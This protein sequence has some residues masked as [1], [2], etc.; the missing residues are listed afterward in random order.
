[1]IRSS[2]WSIVGGALFALAIS[3]P[4]IAPGQGIEWKR[5]VLNE[6]S[7]FEAAGVL[8][9]NNDGTLDIMC[10]DTWYAGPKWEPHH[11]CD[12][13][14]DGEYRIDFANV[15]MDVNGDGWADIVS[16]NW[17]RQSVVWREN[18]G[19]KGGNWIERE[20]DKPGNSETAI[21][22]DVDGDGKI[23]F[24]PDVAQKTIWYRLENGKISGH[25]V[26]ATIGGHG[27]GFGDVNGDG[28]KDILKPGGWFEAPEERLKGTWIWHADWNLGATGEEIITYDFNGDG[29]TDLFYAMGHDFGTFWLEQTKE[30]EPAKK[31]VTHQVDK[32]W[33]Q[34]HSLRLADLDRDGMPDVVTGKRKYAHRTDPGAE[35]PMVI[36]YYSFNRPSKTFMRQEI[37][38]GDGDG[39]GLGPVVT[40]IDGDGD[41]DLVAPGKSG[42]YLFQQENSNK[43]VEPRKAVQE[44]KVPEGFEITLFASEPEIRKPIS[45]AFDERGRMVIC[46]AAEYPLG[47]KPGEKPQDA[48]KILE[49]A[50]G[51]G[52]ADLIKTFADG[53][54]IPDAVAVGHGG[55]YVAEAPDLWFM[56]DTNG[57]DRADEKKSILTNFG[58]QD[59]HHNVHGLIW[60]PEGK[61]L[62]SQGCSTTSKIIADGKEWS[63]IEGNFFRCW[64]DGTGFEVPFRGFTNSWGYD[65]D[66]FG[67][68]VCN[69]NEGPHLIHLVE[70]GDYGFSLPNRHDGKPGTLPGMAT[71]H[72]QHY[73]YLIQSGLTIY[74]GDAFPEEYNGSILQGAPGM[75]KVIR[76]SVEPHGASFL[77]SM[78]T[79]LSST[80]DPWH[81]AI[82]MAVGPDGA[83][84]VLDWY[85]EILAHVEHPLD[86]PRRDKTHGRIYR[87]AWKGA[88]KEPIADLRK[89][90]V[91]ELVANVR[92]DNKWK[93]R[94]S[95][96][97]LAENK[98]EAA[99]AVLRLLVPQEKARTRCH[100]L[101]TLEEMRLAEK[102]ETRAGV[103]HAVQNSLSDPDSRV[104]TVAARIARHIGM[105]DP[106]TLKRIVQL[107]SDTDDFVK[108]EAAL[109]VASLAQ[110]LPLEEVTSMIARADWED[111][112]LAHAFTEAIQPY[113][114]Q[115]VMH[116]FAIGAEGLNGEGEKFLPALLHL[117]DARTEPLFLAFLQL[118]EIKPHLIDELVSGLH[119]FNSPA[120]SKG[121]VAFLAQHPDL[122]PNLI[123]P[124]LEDLRRRPGQDELAKD[125]SIK[126][127]LLKLAENR[128]DSLLRDIFLTASQIGDR[129]LAPRIVDEI[130]NSDAKISESAILSCGE[131]G[132]GEAN[133]QLRAM[134]DQS[135]PR[136]KW[137]T[138]RAL[139]KIGDSSM[140]TVFEEALSDPDSVL[141]CIR[142]LRRIAKQE[143]YKQSLETALRLINEGKVIVNRRTA[144][145]LRE[146]IA[147]DGNAEERAAYSA[148][149]NGFEGIMRDWRIMGPFPNPDTKGHAT[150]YPPESAL[151]PN[152]VCRAF[153]QDLTWQ[154]LHTDDAN[155]IVSLGHLKPNDHVV[156]YAWGTIDSSEERVGTLYAGSDDSIKAWVNGELVLDHLVDRGLEVDQDQAPVKLKKGPNT[157]LVKIGQNGG[158]W[159]FHARIAVL[160]EKIQRDPDNA[161]LR[162]M[163][164]SGDLKRGEKVFF[165][166]V[167]CARCHAVGDKGGRVGPDLS[168]V[169][170]LNPKS[171]IVRSILRPSEEIAEGYAG[172]TI[173]LNS[174]E[175]FEGYIHR[176]TP[177]EVFLVT[178]EGKT[179]TIPKDKI[180]ERRPHSTSGMPDDIAKNITAQ[181]L[182]DLVAFL[183]ERS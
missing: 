40:D 106:E 29:L 167:G 99:A 83:V 179:I 128:R 140:K 156:A 101:W 2:R 49:D 132:L 152:A 127:V 52:H 154:N 50:D 57:D 109:T 183:E 111:P 144:R 37:H 124:I 23:D 1:M 125:P 108:C 65:W 60:G 55:I 16:C 25:E 20:V 7:N 53:L 153:D 121:L 105:N 129:A 11:A 12:I 17:H 175:S 33:S 159:N 133:P 162:A 46:E 28:R 63:L 135:D 70:G 80:E 68:W 6:K 157:V 142:G 3:L 143:D 21:A 54:R 178:A 81:R 62:M 164:L 36:F 72:Q 139:S 8:D 168:N 92:S 134:L 119:G 141:D 56:R 174:N 82:A 45:L 94:I 66:D 39:L 130:H 89:S 76:D 176:E 146:W 5:T 18:P 43:P 58:T 107:T 38:R 10:G 67:N 42:L 171:Y 77:A 85:N 87:I 91:Q 95:Q 73:G 151:D 165:G 14:E 147:K 136:R 100:A 181:E 22:V 69:D 180:K 24:L 163:I 44:F 145:E 90:T 84:Y 35:D 51:D 13:I 116:G 170:R 59:S 15:P 41:L 32:D 79:D 117:R 169:S 131:L 110:P 182:T 148:A 61:L 114:E 137:A 102:P 123:R 64:P 166:S 26:S 47:P 113:K 9:V 19:T 4:G 161:E 74:S 150:P 78:E 177:N 34:G 122:P 88:K 155:G 86:S 173:F 96:R 149:V 115:V 48:V 172:L 126:Q 71:D 103:V 104:R 75:H 120:I 97:L 27:I 158:G 31:W 160:P 98:R 30:T 138:L 93:R 112:Y 118:P